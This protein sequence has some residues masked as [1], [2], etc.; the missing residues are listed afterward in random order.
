MNLSRERLV[1]EAT[2][3][4]FATGPLEKVAYLLAL[5]EAFNRHPVLKGKLALKGGT[6]L[7]MFLFDVP[8]LSVDI[9]LNYIGATERGTMMA[10]RPLLESA[11][12]E[13]CRL[14][15][16]SVQKVPSEH[17]GGTWH[18]RY[19]GTM[20]NTD[21]LKIDVVYMYR[22]PLWTPQRMDSHPI[23]GFQAKGVLVLD[24]YE[25]AA[26]KLAALI[27]RRTSR[28]LFDAHALLTQRGLERERLRLGFVLYGAMNVIDWRT[29]TIQD[30][31]RSAVDF[32]SY[33]APLLRE[34]SRADLL[35]P[36]RGAQELLAECE[37]ALQVVLPLEQ[38]ELDFLE[39]LL[40]YGDIVPELLTTDEAMQERI[41]SHPALSW[42]AQNVKSY[43]SRP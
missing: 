23:G 20:G 36:T 3:T 26:G 5:L 42:K 16:L 18:L 6:A 30:I 40:E 32:D 15:G 1:A 9:D 4:G 29:V 19:R 35:E 43:K 31:E 24:E 12:M 33:L 13:M 28:D 22:N 17:A 7:N 10:E 25:L 38:H 39:R 37:A 27:A 8:R 11:I 14:E 21:S 2:A 34:A 41:R